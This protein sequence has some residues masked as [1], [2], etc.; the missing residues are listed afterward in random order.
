M[1]LVHF[2]EDQPPAALDAMRGALEDYVAEVEDCV[3]GVLDVLYGSPL[4]LE[5]VH[6]QLELFTY[7]ALSV[8]DMDALDA[9]ADEEEVAA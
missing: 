7:A 6:N 9:L 3:E 1:T 2:N 4:D 5:L 8:P